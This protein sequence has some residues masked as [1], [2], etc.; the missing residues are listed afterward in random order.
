[1][2]KRKTAVQLDRLGEASLFTPGVEP[3][4]ESAPK[5]TK[6]L[7]EHLYRKLCTY[8][9]NGLL[10]NQTVQTTL[11]KIPKEYSDKDVS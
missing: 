1:M 10:D 5:K 4:P 3:S 8:N 11:K 7:Q 9:F 2:L 6:S